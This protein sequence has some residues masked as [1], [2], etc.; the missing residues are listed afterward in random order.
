MCECGCGWEGK[1]KEVVISSGTVVTGSCE[2]SDTGSWNRQSSVKVTEVTNHEAIFSA[3]IL[4][5]KQIDNIST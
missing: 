3:P 2:L 5:R 1:T 4:F